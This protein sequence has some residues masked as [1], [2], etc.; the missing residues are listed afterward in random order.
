MV[1][2]FRWVA[3]FVSVSGFLSFL[4]TGENGIKAYRGVKLDVTREMSN[5]ELLKKEL[6]SLRVEIDDWKSD[7]FFAEKTAREEL[8]LGMPGEKVYIIKKST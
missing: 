1:M 8:L 2:L 7:K 5:I 4:I 6:D 3:L